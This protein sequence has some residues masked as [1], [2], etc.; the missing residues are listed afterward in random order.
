MKTAIDV[1]SGKMAVYFDNTAGQA[2][3]EVEVMST[4]N[5]GAD[6]TIVRLA[7]RQS[8]WV[9]LR[10]ALDE[11]TERLRFSV[12]EP[13]AKVFL[14]GLRMDASTPLRWAW[15]NGVSLRWS[16]A[17]G[18]IF[19][20]DL[21]APSIYA[22]NCD[23]RVIDDSGDVVLAELVCRGRANSRKGGRLSR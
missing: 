16:V 1:P 20:R 21:I 13:G 7:A 23:A 11:E 14:R 6:S 9:S 5:G 3:V 15:A 8:G 4:A 18:R 22:P 12:R 2:T 10:L 17:N 19:E